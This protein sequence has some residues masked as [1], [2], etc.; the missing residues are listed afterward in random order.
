MHSTHERKAQKVFYRVFIS[1][2]IAHCRKENRKHKYAIGSAYNAVLIKQEEVKRQQTTYQLWKRRIEKQDRHS[3]SHEKYIDY[4]KGQLI[5]SAKLCK[6]RKYQMPQRRVSLIVRYLK[7]YFLYSSRTCYR[8]RL[9]L[10]KPR[11]VKKRYS[12]NAK[13]VYYQRYNIAF[14]MLF[15]E[16]PA[17]KFLFH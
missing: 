5:G 17:F 1:I 6:W 8:P 13:Q 4:R 12:A 3:K 7:K 2:L 14:S 15:A 9:S 10:I 11:F 16:R